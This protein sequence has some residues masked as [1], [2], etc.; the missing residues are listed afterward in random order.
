MLGWLVVGLLLRLRLALCWWFGWLCGWGVLGV[1]LVV[2]VLGLVVPLVFCWI[3]LVVAWVWCSNLDCCLCGIVWL[4]VSSV[5][6]FYFFCVR[7]F[8]VLGCWPG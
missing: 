1:C 7:V 3:R 6:L 4:I 5:V 8:Y 2:F